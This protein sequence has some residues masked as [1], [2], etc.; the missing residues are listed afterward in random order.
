MHS[1]YVVVQGRIHFSSSGFDQC[2]G[3][4]EMTDQ[5]T[6]PLVEEMPDL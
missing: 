6:M 3:T 5:D 2:L 1:K 4:M